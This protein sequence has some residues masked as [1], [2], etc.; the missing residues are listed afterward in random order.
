MLLTI[1][2]H[3]WMLNLNTN[4]AIFVLFIKIGNEKNNILIRN[5]DN[6]IWKWM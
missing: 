5:L 1:E 2:P 6:Y 4:S 3:I